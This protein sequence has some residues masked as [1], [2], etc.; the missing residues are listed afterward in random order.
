MPA[1]HLIPGAMQPVLSFS[2]VV[3]HLRYFLLAVIK[4]PDGSRLRE[5]RPYLVGSRGHSPSW[6]KAL[7]ASGHITSAVR[8]LRAMNVLG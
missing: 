6:R 7:E 3:L 5:A 4:Y 2:E 8:E 1:V